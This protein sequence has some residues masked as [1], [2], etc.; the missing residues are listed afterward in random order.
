MLALKDS[1]LTYLHQHIYTIEIKINWKFYFL[2]K[3][4]KNCYLMLNSIFKYIYT[5]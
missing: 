2:K 4:K 5:K 1:F 3:K